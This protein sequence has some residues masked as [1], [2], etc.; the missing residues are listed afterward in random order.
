MRY[1]FLDSNI[2]THVEYEDGCEVIEHETRT[3]L[4]CINNRYYNASVMKLDI[5]IRFERIF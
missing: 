5:I 4:A 2:K 1:W 3:A